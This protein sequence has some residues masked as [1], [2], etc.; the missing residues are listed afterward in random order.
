MDFLNQLES[1]NKEDNSYFT[2]NDKNENNKETSLPFPFSSQSSMDGGENA[3]FLNDLKSQGGESFNLGQIENGTQN[4]NFGGL[5]FL[6]TICEVPE[7]SNMIFNSQ[8]DNGFINAIAEQNQTEL[9]FINEVAEKNE[10]NFD[11]FKNNNNNESINVDINNLFKSSKTKKNEIFPKNEESKKNDSFQINN[12]LN[13]ENN[14]KD[15]K[16]NESIKNQGNK[17][18]IK[19][20][21]QANNNNIEKQIVKTKPISKAKE[22]IIINP[23]LKNNSSVNNKN[24]NN[25]K[26]SSITIINN[27]NNLNK[28]IANNLNPSPN[29]ISIKEKVSSNI[30]MNIKNSSLPIPS[31]NGNSFKTNYNIKDNK[32]NMPSFPNIQIKPPVNNQQKINLD[33]IDQIISLNK[34]IEN[35]PNIQNIP[36]LPMNMISLN[37]NFLP[38]KQDNNKIDIGK[39]NLKFLSNEISNLFNSSLINGKRTETDPKDKDIQNIDTLLNFTKEK[40]TSKSNINKKQS[41]SKDKINNLYK[42]INTNAQSIMNNTQKSNIPNLIPLPPDSFDKKSKLIKLN[43]NDSV[44][45][46]QM[47]TTSKHIKKDEEKGKAPTKLEMI[48]KYNDLASRLNKIREKAKE[49]R[50]IGN[51]FSQL[52]IANENYNVVYPNVLKKLLEEYNER[53]IKLLSL[54]KIKNNKLEEKNNEFFEEVK[55]YSLGESNH[56]LKA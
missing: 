42:Q 23:D 43:K 40:I 12:L 50:N 13:I 45:L 7:S 55:K 14:D 24:N 38:S 15:N 6:N 5:D 56:S 52:I 27:N 41:I 16:L 26:L 8:S 36:N 22:P 25:N 9:D 30:N 44:Y 39:D 33:D 54:M 53:T 4:N 49:Y 32:E 21:A 19:N 48:Q 34:K 18:P 10:N 31:S 51:Y 37:K 17:N 2:F 46:S 11:K 28:Q 1:D 20:K 3:M 47:E 35:K 29:T